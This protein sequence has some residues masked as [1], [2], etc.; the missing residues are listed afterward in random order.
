VRVKE[1]SPE[2]LNS[3]TQ[4]LFYSSQTF[5]IPEHVKRHRVQ[6]MLPRQLKVEGLS[7]SV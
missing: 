3:G 7:I 4:S 6:A 2:L 5:K 1:A